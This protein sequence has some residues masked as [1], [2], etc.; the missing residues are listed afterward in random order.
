MEID[1]FIILLISDILSNCCL[2]YFRY[3]DTCKQIQSERLREHWYLVQ[4]M[5]FKFYTFLGKIVNIIKPCPFI[6]H[7]V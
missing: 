6:M 7:E 3:N 2:V 1:R 5:N 4:I